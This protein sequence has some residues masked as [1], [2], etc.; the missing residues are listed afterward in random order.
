LFERR[1]S[2][3]NSVL[4]HAVD[5]GIFEL[6]DTLLASKIDCN[7][8]NLAGETPLHVASARNCV[9]A[10]N[11]LLSN[12]AKV[13]AV[14]LKG[15]TPLFYAIESNSKEAFEALVGSRASLQAADEDGLRATELLAFKN[16]QRDTHSPPHSASS[17]LHHVVASICD[18]P[19]LLHALPTSDTTH[20]LRSVV[21]KK[22][23][24]RN[25]NRCKAN[26]AAASKTKVGS[27]ERAKKLKE[28]NEYVDTISKSHG[29]QLAN[30][31]RMHLQNIQSD[32]MPPP[33]Q[34]SRT[35]VGFFTP[36]ASHHSDAA[37]P[38][39]AGPHH[40]PH[41]RHT[42]CSPYDATRAP[43]IYSLDPN[44]GSQICAMGKHAQLPPKPHRG[45]A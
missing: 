13:D 38:G 43:P 41:L 32:A 39:A 10:V 27:M 9:N 23:V 7:I 35:Q 36:T 15:R 4:H 33:Q 18:E 5:L 14:N 16:A 17:V 22:L 6:L 21:S 37:L 11:V 28:L 8:K 42:F 1:D 44:I 29:I 34:P 40:A 19:Q 25:S 24:A 26:L 20:S 31:S 2:A 12:N 30:Q 3:G 45:N